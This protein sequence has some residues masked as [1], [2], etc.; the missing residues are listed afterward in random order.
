[1][2]DG[3]PVPSS[4]P[5]R[6][7]SRYESLDAWRGITCLAVIVYHSTIFG[8]EAQPSEALLSVG[9]ALLFVASKC[10]YGVM[11]FFVISG[12]CIAAAVDASARRGTP[13][14]DYVW[15]RFRRIFPPFWARS[16]RSIQSNGLPANKSCSFPLADALLGNPSL[17]RQPDG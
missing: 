9:G 17:C 15:R 7:S 5:A 2:I 12:Y 8:A 1:M 11:L 4:R 13:I 10:F 16:S 14:A 3:S 6:P